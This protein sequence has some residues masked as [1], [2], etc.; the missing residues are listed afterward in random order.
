MTTTLDR[1][2]R[3]L[4]LLAT[5]ALLCALAAIGTFFVT[6][7]LFLFNEVTVRIGFTLC[8]GSWIALYALAMVT[9]ICQVGLARKDCHSPPPPWGPVAGVLLAGGSM[10]LIWLSEPP[11]PGMLIG[12]LVQCLMVCAPLI[13]LSTLAA[14]RYRARHPV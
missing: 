2:G 3:L 14:V 7:M 11:G 5:V 13:V 10:I 1:R 12:S 6:G 4:A 8:V 9:A